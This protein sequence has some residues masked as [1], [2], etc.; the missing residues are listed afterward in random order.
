MRSLFHSLFVALVAILLA[1]CGNPW[2]DRPAS[3]LPKPFRYAVAKPSNFVF[4]NYCGLGT[5]T[6]DLTAR[7]VGRLDEICFRHDSCYVDRRNHCDCDRI[8]VHEASLI[9]DDTSEPKKTRRQAALLVNTFS[10]GVCKVF[11]EGFLPPR[12]RDRRELGLPAATEPAVTA[13]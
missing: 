6:G 5:R 3:D 10:L 13:K 8:L 1:A 12:P 4:G 2:G 11:P 7:P 9:R